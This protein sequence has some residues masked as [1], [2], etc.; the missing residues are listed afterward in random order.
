MKTFLRQEI[1]YQ[2]VTHH[3][4]AKVSKDLYK[5]N[6][7]SLEDMIKNLTVM[8]SDEQNNEGVVFLSEE[9]VV[10]ILKGNLSLPVTQPEV[11][12]TVCLLPN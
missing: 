2:R 4:D 7:V 10:N 3:R 9:E 12:D 8:L 1:Q 11:K 6:N 5:V